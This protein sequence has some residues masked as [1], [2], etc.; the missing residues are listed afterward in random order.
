MP[1]SIVQ[2]AQVRLEELIDANLR[3]MRTLKSDPN[4]SENSMEYQKLNIQTQ[5]YIKKKDA[6]AARRCM[7]RSPWDDFFFSMRFY[8]WYHVVHEE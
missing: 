4:I 6:P 5:L 1:H 7:D 2:I 3:V 8:K